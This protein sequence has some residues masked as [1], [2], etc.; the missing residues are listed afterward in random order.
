M[1]LK[2]LPFNFFSAVTW[3]LVTSLLCLVPPSSNSMILI[4]IALCIKVHMKWNFLLIHSKECSK[5]GRM[6]FILLW[7]HYCLPS[8]TRIFLCKLEDKHDATMRTQ[9]DVKSQ[10]IEYL[11]KYYI[12]RVEIS[13]VWCTARTTHCD[14]GY[15]VTIATYLLPD[16]YFPKMK[17]ASFVA[18]E[19]NGLSFAWAVKCPYLHTPTECTITA[20]NTSWRRKTL[21]LP[22]EWRGPG[23]HCVAMEMSQWT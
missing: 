19:F 5:W 4:V 18:P 11:C 12:Y 3:F 17:N 14:S 8:Y 1:I 2:F 6:V 7:Y 9:S 10:K 23:A 20:N 16:L 13:Q 21:I 15:D 22:F